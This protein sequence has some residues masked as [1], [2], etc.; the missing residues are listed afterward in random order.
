MAVM[1]YITQRNRVRCN[2]S[3]AESKTG[4]ARRIVAESDSNR[5][6]AQAHFML[7]AKLP[8]DGGGLPSLDILEVSRNCSLR[9]R[10]WEGFGEQGSERELFSNALVYMK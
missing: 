4:E 9:R 6:G 2:K 10:F 3:L 7:L 1:F 8:L 5:T